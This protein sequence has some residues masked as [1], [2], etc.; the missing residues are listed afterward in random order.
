[1][2]ILTDI[3]HF[4]TGIPPIDLYDLGTVLH[5]LE[6]EGVDKGSKPE[7][8]DLPAP[9]SFHPLEVQVLDGNIPIAA[10][11]FQG[12]LEVKILPLICDSL[13]DTG[14]SFSRLP[15]IAAARLL[16]AEFFTCL[17]ELF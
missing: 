6:L 11:Q 10:N 9:E 12:Q 16:R 14:K 5:G 4:G 3:A 15:P 13:M 8:R 1:M 17:P 7:I 2:I